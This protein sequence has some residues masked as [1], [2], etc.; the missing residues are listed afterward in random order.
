M[1]LY[2]LALVVRSKNAGPFT[3]TVD[4]VFASMGDYREA[5]GSPAL[6]PGRIASVY[7]L[8]PEQVS[9]HPFERIRTIKVSMPRRTSSGAPGDTDV[10]GSQQHFPLAAMEV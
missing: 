5:L 3:V 4:L 2:D 9:I 8:R 10:Y 6:T 7:G 1:R